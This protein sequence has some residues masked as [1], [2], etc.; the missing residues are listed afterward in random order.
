V[1]CGLQDS[2][3]YCL[4]LYR[5]LLNLFGLPVNVNFGNRVSLFYCSSSCGGLLLWCCQISCHTAS[6]LFVRQHRSSKPSLARLLS[7]H[8]AA[9]SPCLYGAADVFVA[10]GPDACHVLWPTQPSYPP[11]CGHAAVLRCCLQEVPAEDI[12]DEH[13]ALLDKCKRMLVA[14]GAEQ[15][16]P[17]AGP[18]RRQQQQQHSTQQQHSAAAAPAALRTARQRCFACRT[19]SRLLFHKWLSPEALC[20][21]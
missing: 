18:V 11:C 21:S 1:L 16:I 20:C 4:G 19:G 2:A 8:P 6:V 10:A 5:G 15:H 9:P 3:I 7:W 17:G 14:T 12:T 13:K